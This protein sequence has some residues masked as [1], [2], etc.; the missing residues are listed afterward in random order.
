MPTEPILRDVASELQTERLLLRCP[1]A[2]DGPVLHEAVLESLSA[3]RAWPASLPWAMREPAIATSETFCRE[4]M[5]RFI[6]RA[7]F[8]YLA[9][10]RANGRFV[11]CIGVHPI[12]WNVPK[13]EVG[14]WCR[15]A[16]HR[17]G[18][19]REAVA[20]VVDYAID[21][22]GARRVAC[23]TDEKNQAARSL[24][25]G[26]GMLLEATLRHER[27]TPAGELRNTCIYAK[28]Q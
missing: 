23:V 13:F 15:S 18:F 12:D 2:G 8:V 11:A 21:S 27:V 16:A 10:E 3:L 28:A 7:G 20:A 1:A 4:S 22:L 9:F 17:R 6:S 14:F 5:A 25:E 19:T 24:C 26:I